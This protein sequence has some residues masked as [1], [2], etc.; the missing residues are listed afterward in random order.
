MAMA[1]AVVALGLIMVVGAIYTIVDAH[2]YMR[3][4]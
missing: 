1:V 3:E 4:D 2:R